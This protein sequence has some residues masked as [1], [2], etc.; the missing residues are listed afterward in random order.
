MVCHCQAAENETKLGDAGKCGRDCIYCICHK[1]GQ[2]VTLDEIDQQLDGQTDINF[3]DMR[4][5]LENRGFFCETLLFN[6]KSIGR[7][8]K[9]FNHSKEPIYAVAALPTSSE[10][11]H[12]FVIITQC[13]GSHL[14]IFDASSNRTASVN[15]ADYKGKPII[16]PVLLVSKEPIQ[17]QA[18]SK[19]E[20]LLTIAALAVIFCIGYYLVTKNRGKY[21]FWNINI[22]LQYCFNLLTF[23]RLSGVGSIVM[24]FVLLGFSY[25][26]YYY[27]E[28][29]LEFLEPKVD[30]GDIELF[31]KNDI[32]VAVRNRSFRQIAIE[33]VQV[34]CSC[35]TIEEYPDVIEPKSV[36][37]FK[38]TLVPLL[39]GNV[40]YQTL[41]VPQSFAPMIGKISYNGYQ[42]VQILPKYINIG[43]I[44]RG[45]QKTFSCEYTI[46]D[47]RESSMLVTSVQ[48][49][50]DEP[51]F[52]VVD[53]LPKELRNGD[54]FTIAIKHLGNAPAGNFL[55]SFE[56][57]G[58][59]DTDEEIILLSNI[60]G[61]VIP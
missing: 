36:Q 44:E 7:L 12:H 6:A 25:R 51:I 26:E 60:I 57:R 59:G 16:I 31:S 33:D 40:L 41:I 46:K 20:I 11:E 14:T 3:A 35:L 9:K 48:M 1:F 15:T 19:S 32:Y 49:H 55:Q 61:L 54:A 34:S 24:I 29:P 23:R 53:K 58:K 38:L 8:Q 2:Q 43:L 37:K 52:E 13:T 56:I 18:F 5:A 17:Y 42:R 30:L 4:K 47:L 39:E 27:H 50:G 10:T 21:F 28:H 45:E 22:A